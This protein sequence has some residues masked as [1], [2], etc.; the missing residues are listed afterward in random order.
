M[1]FKEI[2]ANRARVDAHIFVEKSWRHAKTYKYVCY[3]GRRGALLEENLAHV[4]VH[5][6]YNLHK[7]SFIMHAEYAEGHPHRGVCAMEMFQRE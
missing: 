3:L 4:T 7:I 6:A 5:D 2:F 1:H